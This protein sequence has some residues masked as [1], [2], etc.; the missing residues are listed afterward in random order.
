MKRITIRLDVADG[1]DEQIGQKLVDLFYNMYELTRFNH[2]VQTNWDVVANGDVKPD[3][4][5][6]MVTEPEAQSIRDVIDNVMKNH[7]CDELTA[8]A[9]VR[10]YITY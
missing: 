4:E 7:G 10:M 2:F 9:A 8:T 6:P 1:E 5:I 3:A